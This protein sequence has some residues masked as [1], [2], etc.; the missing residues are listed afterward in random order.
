[1]KRG[2]HHVAERGQKMDKTILAVGIVVVIVRVGVVTVAVIV[3][4]NHSLTTVDL[5][6]VLL[7]PPLTET[8]QSKGSEINRVEK[9][10]SS[11]SPLIPPVN[12]YAHR[13]VLLRRKRR[14]QQSSDSSGK[15]ESGS[16]PKEI[17]QKGG[18]E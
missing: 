14:G 17:K 6:E 10:P 2:V 11:S 7:A 8:F 15:S 12:C 5:L 18:I 4:M 3:R 1:M 16:F 13:K 9:D